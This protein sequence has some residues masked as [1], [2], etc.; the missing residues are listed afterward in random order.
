MPYLV[1]KGG[2]RAVHDWPIS[3]NVTA[4]IGLARA[5]F[6]RARFD[7]LRNFPPPKPHYKYDPA[8]FA[9]YRAAFATYRAAVGPDSPFNFGATYDPTRAR[10][11]LAVTYQQR[12]G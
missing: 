10:A 11:E 2:I 1:T 8:A 7:R 4:S 6:A 5:R 9:T 3:E 12:Q